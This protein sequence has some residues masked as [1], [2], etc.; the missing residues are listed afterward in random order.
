MPSCCNQKSESVTRP[1]Y[2]EVTRDR[3]SAGVCGCVRGRTVGKRRSNE[4]LWI[5]EVY[6]PNCTHTEQTAA[7]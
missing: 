5:E 2:L 6:S 4:G 7:T 1:P 3:A